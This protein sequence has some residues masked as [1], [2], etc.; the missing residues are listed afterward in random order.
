MEDYPELEC[1]IPFM[2][3]DGF[4]NVQDEYWT[5]TEAFENSPRAWGVDMRIGAFERYTKDVAA[6]ML[7]VLPVRGG[8]K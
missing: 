1:W 3:H 2:E 4:S 5:A 6:R 8:R 7:W